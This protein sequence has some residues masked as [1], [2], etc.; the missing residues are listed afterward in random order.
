MDRRYKNRGGK[1]KEFRKVLIANRGEIALR[2]IRTLKEMGIKSV[3][4]YSEADRN[5][6][7]IRMAD[8]SICI[9]PGPSKE[10]YLKMENIISAALSC[11]ADAIH[12]GYG[13]LSENAEF[14]KLCSRHNIVFIGPSPDSIKLL[15]HKSQAREIASKAGVPITPG[16]DGCIKKDFLKEAKKIGFPIMIKAAAGG[17]GRGIRIVYDENKLLYEVEMAQNEAKAAFGNDEIYF[18]KFIEQPRHIEIQFIRDYNGKIIAFPERDCSIQR[19]N[20]KLIEETPSPAVNPQLRKKLQKAVYNLADSAD[21]HGAGTVEFL[22]D[23]NGNF[24]FMEVNTR[25]QVE[26]PITEAITGVDLV[27]EQILIA[28]KKCISIN[29]EDVDNFTG[30]SIEHRI[31][32]EDW[33]NN[34]APSLGK[35]EEWIMPGGPGIRIDSHIYNGYEIPFY[36]DSMIAKLIIWAKDRNSAIS[37]SNRALDEF[38]IKGIKTTI[39]AHKKIINSPEFMSGNVDTKFLERFLAEEKN[40]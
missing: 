14:S 24:Y 7:H 6:L 12:P 22:L 31:N 40:K 28:Q 17:G 11:Q 30:H 27:K 4:V 29:Q 26:H 19:R 1:V 33:E 9:G 38:K 20:Q 3:A 10:S 23:K 21:Y 5:S 2:V 25:L 13:F 34:F 16:T 15:G 35:I 8:E 36:Y 37:R 32:A 39:G 18:E